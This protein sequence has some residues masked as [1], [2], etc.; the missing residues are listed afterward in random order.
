MFRL[1]HSS[2][3]SNAGSL[4]GFPE[5]DL[6]TEGKC[7][8]GYFPAWLGQP[9]LEGKY[10][11]VRKL[12]WGSYSSVWLARDQEFVVTALAAPY[13]FSNAHL[14]P[15]DRRSRF[16][17]LKL[18]TVKGT[19]AMRQKKIDEPGL[20]EKV[21]RSRVE[22]SHPGRA[23][24]LDLFDTFSIHGPLGE[25]LCLVT[26]VLG[27]DLGFFRQAQP[28]SQVPVPIVKHIVRQILLGLDFLHGEC[29]I[30]HSGQCFLQAS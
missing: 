19:S 28:K 4:S 13:I 30:V 8:M 10:V 25:Q 1:S 7:N 20:L 21:A 2:S 5:E 23:H 27:F 17:A 3:S 26:E 15:L 11:I 18:L 22:S 16:A 14:D 29:G 6:R 9:F 12:G 24:V